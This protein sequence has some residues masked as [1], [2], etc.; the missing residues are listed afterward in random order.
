MAEPPMEG[1]DLAR[2]VTPAG[3]GRARPDLRRR[4]ARGRASTPASRARS[5][6]TC[7]SAACGSSC[8]LHHQRRGAAG[9][10]PRRRLP[11]QR[12][13]RPGR[14]RLRR[15]HGAR[16]GGQGAGVRASAWATSC[17][18]ARSASRPSSCPSATAAPTTR[19][20]T[21]RRGGSRS[22]PRTTASRSS[23]PAASRTIDTDEPVRW[24]TDFGAA[25]LTQLNLY[26]R[27]VEGLVLR[28]VPGA[29]VQYH[30]E[31][32]PGPA[33][34]LHLF[35]RFLGRREGVRQTSRWN[36]LARHCRLRLSTD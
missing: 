22:P 34:R 10:R 32:G 35:D 31:A 15:R 12:P 17:S 4:P 6:A 29:T 13:G 7:A 28:D 19:S 18:A 11:R 5:C 23:A 16:A 24:E 2:E 14:A 26:D 27:T 36:C 1:Q 33:R 30:P 25:E 8:T 20:R 3:G 9:Q 21:S